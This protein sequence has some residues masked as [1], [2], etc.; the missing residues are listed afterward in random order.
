MG[1]E[2]EKSAVDQGHT[3]E[4]GI[5]PPPAPPAAVAAAPLAPPAPPAAGATS[6]IHV[7]LTP[8]PPP[9]LSLAVPVSGA[10]APIAQPSLVAPPPVQAVVG[11]PAPGTAVGAGPAPAHLV[12]PAAAPVQP[13]AQRLAESQIR[14]AAGGNA[15]AHRER[16]SPRRRPSSSYR[17]A[18]RGGRGGLW[19]GHDRRRGGPSEMQQLCEDFSRMLAAAMRNALNGAPN[20]GSSLAPAAPAPAPAPVNVQAPAAPLAAP[21]PHAS[22]YP[23]VPA[24]GGDRA[25]HASLH[26]VFAAPY[27]PLPWIPPLPDTGFVGAGGGEASGAFVPPRQ[28]ADIPSLQPPPP[29]P[30][31][32][33]VQTTG[34]A[35]V[36]TATL[37]QF[38]PPP[39]SH[40]A[41]VSLPCRHPS[42]SCQ[43][44]PFSPA[45]S[46]P[47]AALAGACLSSYSSS[48]CC[49]GFSKEGTLHSGSGV[50]LW[51]RWDPIVGEELSRSAQEAVSWQVQL[52]Q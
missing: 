40:R 31:P 25:L 24:P 16:G 50:E 34:L 21:A 52:P 30:V 33:V 47:Q 36:P 13:V 20:L 3:A 46:T 51:W 38:T 42:S 23:R 6:S 8:A 19:G 17:S 29:L 18:H 35:Q 22:A 12:A 11:G 28:R 9:S 32:A 15:A 43:R 48:K 39:A 27:P 49:S 14:G 1:T 41:H 26:P 37:A 44:V 2:A 7:L 45:P 4:S 5:A 10:P